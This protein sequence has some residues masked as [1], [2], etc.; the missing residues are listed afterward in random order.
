MSL[1]LT[2]IDLKKAFDSAETEAVV[3][4]LDNQGI[5]AQYIKRGVRQGD[6]I[7]PKIFTTTIE[8]AM[9]KLELDDM[10]VKH[11]LSGTNVDRIR[12]NMWMHRSS[13]ES[14]K[15]DVHAQRMGLRCSIHAQ[16]RNMSECTSYVYL[17]RELNMMNDLTPELGRRR[18]AFWGAY[19]SIANVVKKTRN[20]RLRAHLFNTTVLTALTYASETWAFRKQEENAIIVINMTFADLVMCLCYMLTRPYL[21]LFPNMACNPYYV[22]IWTIQLVSCVN[23]VW[24]NVDKLIFIQFPLHYYSIINRKKVLILMAATWIVLGYIS[25]T[26]ES[27]MRIAARILWFSIFS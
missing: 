2:F 26:V 9:R 5:P 12:R 7:S 16:W 25:F 14:P 4:A 10:G 15:D 13:A 23:L 18:G 24:L 17:D 3:D 8:N 21:S 27:F 22:T 19:K 6:S 11:Q 20:T 1:C